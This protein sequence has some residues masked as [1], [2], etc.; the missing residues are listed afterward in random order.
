MGGGAEH[1][2]DEINTRPSHT[3]AEE[4]YILAQN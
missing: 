1:G 4:E 3:Q 2:L